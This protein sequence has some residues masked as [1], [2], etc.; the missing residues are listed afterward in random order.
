[1]R[2]KVNIDGEVEIFGVEKIKV[3]SQCLHLFKK[4]EN[5][6]IPYASVRTG[7]S[8]EDEATRLLQ[9]GWADLSNYNTCLGWC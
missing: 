9:N 6:R 2:V 1:M 5:V 3:K 4:D 8:T 7:V